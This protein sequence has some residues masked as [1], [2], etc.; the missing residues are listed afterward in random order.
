MSNRTSTETIVLQLLYV[1]K[2]NIFFKW[3]CALIFCNHNGVIDLG[4][5]EDTVIRKFSD[6]VYKDFKIY[7]KAFL[8]NSMMLL[9]III[10]TL[11]MINFH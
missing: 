5:R 4:I 2:E 8:S 9:D 11:F 7:D 1:Q 6:S 10:Y 3:S